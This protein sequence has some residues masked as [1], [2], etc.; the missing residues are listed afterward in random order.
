MTSS[1]RKVYSGEEIPV[2]RDD[3]TG[4]DT[5]GN[6][7]FELKAYTEKAGVWE[8]AIV[9]YSYTFTNNIPV[10][11]DGKFTYDGTEQKLISSN[12]FYTVESISGGGKIDADGNATAKKAGTYKVTL[13][14]NDGYKWAKGD[15]TT[16]ADQVVTFTINPMS[17]EDAVIEILSEPE[18]ANGEPIEPKIRVT[19]YGEELSPDDYDIIYTDNI[20]SGEGKVRVKGK[21][22][23]TGETEDVPFEIMKGEFSL[24]FNLGGGTLNGQTG[25]YTMVCEEGSTIKMPLPTRD[26][27]V[28]DYWKG[29]EYLAGDDYTVVENH[30]F[31]AIW[32]KQGEKGKYS[33]GTNPGT[34]KTGDNAPLVVLTIVMI[35]SLIGIA[36]VIL[37]RRKR[38]RA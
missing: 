35:L 5:E 17:L 7:A 26:G 24:T 31:E 21:G 10:P 1:T 22:N 18:R 16:V 15:D 27:Y 25:T 19:L 33:D 4:V 11:E 32:V 28:F 9:S 6:K 12:R 36:G 37:I 23:Y 34:R 8:S 3:A 13:K 20:K 2:T 38:R 29:S 30:T 14:I